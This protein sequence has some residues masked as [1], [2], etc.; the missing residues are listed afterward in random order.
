MTARLLILVVLTTMLNVACESDDRPGTFV[1]PGPTVP[2]SLPT[3]T[4]YVWDS[5][6]ELAVWVNNSVSKGSFTIDGSGNAAIIRV[7]RPDSQW[8]LRGPDLSP[9]PTD[10]RTV[11]IRYRWVPDASLSPTASR[12]LQVTAYFE[13]TAKLPDYYY[14]QAAAWATLEPREE[15]SEIAFRPG[16]YTPPIDVRYVYFNCFGGNRGVLEIDRIALLR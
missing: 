2:S 11:E 8:T 3:E 9:A 1:I 4:P 5:R 10:V 14:N 16:Q 6:E 12:T 7:D 13:T 15:L